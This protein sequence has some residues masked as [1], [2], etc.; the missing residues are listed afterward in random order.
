MDDL[1]IRLTHFEMYF[2]SVFCVFVCEKDLP[3]TG[4]G[5]Y[6]AGQTLS[7]YSMY[8]ESG[9]YFFLLKESRGMNFF[10]DKK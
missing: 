10:K 4:P 8:K 2:S 6:R 7:L 5:I 9:G 1:A 3:E